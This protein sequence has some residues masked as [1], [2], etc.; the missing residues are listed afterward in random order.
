M[1]DRES[2]ETER[3]LS[4]TAKESKNADTIEEEYSKNPPSKG[5]IETTHDGQGSK[6][7][8]W[9]EGGPYDED[10]IDDGCGN[11]Y[12]RGEVLDI[13]L[14]YKRD[15][16]N[17]FWGDL[18]NY[19]NKMCRNTEDSWYPWSKEMMTNLDK[20][21]R[22]MRNIVNK[23]SH[24]VIQSI[25]RDVGGE[26]WRMRT[27]DKLKSLLGTLR[28]I[29]KFVKSEKGMKTCWGRMKYV[30][31]FRHKMGAQAKDSETETPKEFYTEAME[32]AKYKKSL[33]ENSYL[34][35]EEKRLVYKLYSKN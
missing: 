8:H 33:W 32:Y 26:S 23:H 13:V 15:S 27:E 34:D 3:N 9:I 24:S 14:S 7:K 10:L 4:N 17:F 6:P 28:Q 20:N 30:G 19:C 18:Q 5:N 21:E 16:R 1:S 12:N 35:Q 2:E 22:K 25:C 31:T 11:M 29:E